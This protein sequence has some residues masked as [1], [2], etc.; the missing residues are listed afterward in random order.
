MKIFLKIFISFLL[1][2]AVGLGALGFLLY[3]NGASL[4]DLTAKYLA[5]SAP[6]TMETAAKSFVESCESSAK[7]SLQKD[8]LLT[9]EKEMKIQKFC[10][11]AK[12]QFKQTF[13]SEEVIGIGL[14]K[15]LSQNLNLPEDKL[16]KIVES[17][18]TNL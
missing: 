11:C 18:K 15:M 3:K 4:K 16:N 5:H 1:I 9:P 2:L 17:C 12:I 13:T 14:N 7:A 10:E 6:S 8:G